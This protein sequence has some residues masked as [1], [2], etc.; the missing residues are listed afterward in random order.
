MARGAPGSRLHRHWDETWPRL[1]HLWLKKKGPQ[2]RSSLLF[3]FSSYHYPCCCSLSV[4]PSPSFSILHPSFSL[5]L[6]SLALCC[7]PPQRDLLKCMES[8]AEECTGKAVW[9]RKRRLR[10]RIWYRDSNKRV[11]SLPFKWL[12]KERE[13]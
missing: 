6:P 7:S 9:L 8:E 5:F 11:I 1:Q 2:G 4:R 13:G 10:H 3:C 12:L